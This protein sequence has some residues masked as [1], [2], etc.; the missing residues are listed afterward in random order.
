MICQDVAIC[1][2]DYARTERLAALRGWRLRR[3]TVPEKLSKERIIHKGET[4]AAVAPDRRQ[5]S[6]RGNAPP[7]RAGVGPQ[8]QVATLDCGDIRSTECIRL[9]SLNPSAASRIPKTIA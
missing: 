7:G 6:L 3:T 1:A 9:R 5:S 8:L 2:H 4:V